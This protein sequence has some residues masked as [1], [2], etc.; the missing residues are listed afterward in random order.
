MRVLEQNN[1]DSTIVRSVARI[2]QSIS[3]WGIIDKVGQQY[4]QITV[5]NLNDPA[6]IEWLLEIVLCSQP[7]RH[8]S[9]VDLVR[10]NELFPFEVATQSRAIVHTSSR[11]A[12]TL[13]GLDRETV[14]L[15]L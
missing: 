6:V 10:A 5:I 7:T 12:V 1:V 2:I 3:A 14:G 11:F 9:L 13:E 8:L 15:S 4:R